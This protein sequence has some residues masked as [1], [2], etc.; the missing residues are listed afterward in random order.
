MPNVFSCVVGR[1]QVRRLD[2]LDM[3]T[4]LPLNVTAQLI[5]GDVND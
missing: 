4:P 5:E 3:K 1:Q 2:I